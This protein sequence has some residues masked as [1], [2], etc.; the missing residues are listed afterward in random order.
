MTKLDS[1]TNEQLAEWMNAVL[2]K[3]RTGVAQGENPFGAGIFPLDGSPSAI[4]FNQAK[5][6]LNPAAHAEVCAIAAACQR[7]GKR[8][9]GDYWLLATAE[10]C[11]MC[12]SAAAIAGIRYIAFGAPQSVVTQAGYG[13]LGVDGSRLADQFAQEIA[14]RSSILSEQ[15][16]SLLLNH[17]ESND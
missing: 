4:E 7:L 11:P 14:L 16:S 10:P 5:S 17:P 12:M 1:I 13:S 2:D 6:T 15:C 3:T 8:D 9:L